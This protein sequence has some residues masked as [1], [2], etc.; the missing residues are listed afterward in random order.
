MDALK[1]WAVSCRLNLHSS[2]G[3]LR[4]QQLMAM[5]RAASVGLPRLPGMAPQLFT[6]K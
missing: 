2:D 5:S 1:L 3:N 4:L 6:L